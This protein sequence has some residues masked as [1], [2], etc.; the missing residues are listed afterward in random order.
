MF[1]IWTEFTISLAILLW[2]LRWT[3]TR[4]IAKRPRVG[5]PT[6]GIWPLILAA[7]AV[8]LPFPLPD[9]KFDWLLRLAILLVS[10]GV[11]TRLLSPEE[12]IVKAWKMVGVHDAAEHHDRAI[13]RT[14][15]FTIVLFGLGWRHGAPEVI[16]VAVVAL[17][18]CLVTDIRREMRFREAHGF[19]AEVISTDRVELAEAIAGHLLDDGIPVMVRGLSVGRLLRL[20]RR[21]LEVMVPSERMVDVERS[22]KDTD[23]ELSWSDDSV[24][25]E[26]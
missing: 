10:Q 17:A 2:S 25:D 26:V 12:R 19:C 4:D 8:T 18:A 9:S 21:T 24:P 14:T 11:L 7:F 3:A 15:V 16:A 5:A 20:P 23:I 1:Q 6:S 13:L 22:L